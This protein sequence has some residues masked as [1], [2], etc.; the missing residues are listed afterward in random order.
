MKILLIVGLIIMNLYS[1]V[2]MNGYLYY[3]PSSYSDAKC[4]NYTAWINAGTCYNP[5]ATTCPTFEVPLGACVAAGIWQASYYLHNENIVDPESGDTLTFN[6]NT[7]LYENSDN[8]ITL[9]PLNLTDGFTAD[10]FDRQ[11]SGNSPNT[12]DGSSPNDPSTCPSP[13]VCSVNEVLINCECVCKPGFSPNPDQNYECTANCLTPTL[14]PPPGWNA[15]LNVYNTDAE[16]ASKAS[17]F[18]NNTYI[19]DVIDNSVGMQ[20]CRFAVCFVDETPNDQ[21]TDRND[22]ITPADFVF[23]GI[24][25]SALE[26]DMYV[27]GVGY[28]ASKT[29]RV[30]N[31]CASDTRSYCFLKPS[32]N[33]PDSG[34]P[35]PPADVPINNIPS[36]VNNPPALT[37]PDAS[38]NIANNQELRK[39][40][41]LL[42][43]INNQLSSSQNN[44]I[45][46]SRLESTTRDISNKITQLANVNTEGF[47][48]VVDSI[49][50]LEL[51]TTSIDYTNLLETENN[52]TQGIKDSLQVDIEGYNKLDEQG[53]ADMIMNDFTAVKDSFDNL[54]LLLSS[55]F[56]Y[57]PNTGN[58]VPMTA[59]V[60]GGTLTF[61]I[62]SSMAVFAP[63]IRFMV[64]VGGF[65]IAIRIY[66]KM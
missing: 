2:F 56:E 45:D 35:I 66:F 61:D 28:L 39:H 12:G 19:F 11:S 24:V 10:D 53:F 25:A 23:M 55:G 51:N 46:L 50:N 62:C 32:F 34:L 59:N 4:H 20:I 65:L 44:N 8:S 15:Y 64:I 6:E 47:S 43:E 40:T 5:D 36:I 17:T 30:F 27:D 13:P 21:C 29:K 54:K 3:P 38:D 14:N 16:C 33:N 42:R 26:C 37:P 60:L 58:Y 41:N 22:L 63:I 31:N 1:Q 57:T 7:G 49:N 18:P 48:N 52:L 9:N